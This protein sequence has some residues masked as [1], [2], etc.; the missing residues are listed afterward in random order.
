PGYPAK[1][2]A[3]EGV[4]VRCLARGSPYDSNITDSSISGSGN[5]P[6][7]YMPTSLVFTRRSQQGPVLST[8]KYWNSSL[9]ESAGGGTEMRESF[10]PSNARSTNRGTKSLA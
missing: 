9:G 3:E 2:M 4:P 8:A 5:S 6:G 1:W 10:S 7:T